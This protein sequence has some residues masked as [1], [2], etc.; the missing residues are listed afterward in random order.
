MRKKLPILLSLV[1]ILAAFCP[2]FTPPAR[3]RAGQNLDA[4]ALEAFFDAY[5]SAEMEKNHVAGA[6]V[7]VVQGEQPLFS[8]GYGYA[9]VAEGLPVDP[10]KTVFILG[11]LSKLFTWTAVMQL[12]ERGQLDLDADVN[13]YLDFHIPDTYPQPI[14]LNHL[15][16]HNAGFEER[17]FGQMAATPGQ[18]TSL[19]D[20]LKSHLPARVRPPGQFSA[21]ENYGAALAGYIVERVSGMDYAEYVEQNILAPL[22]MAHTTARQPIPAALETDMSQGYAFAN[23]AYRPQAGF[24]VAA[25]VAPAAS[26][27]A[28]AGDMA[29]FMLAHLNDGRGL[30]QPAT[31]RWMHTR[32]FAHDP[33][34]NG[35]AHGFWE[36]DMNGQRIIGH[37]GSHFIFS[38]C[39]LLFPEQKLGVFLAVNSQ[40]GMAFV[41]GQNY[42]RFEQAFVDHFFPRELP[43]LS[44]PADFAPRANRFSG[45][46]HLTMGRAQTSPEKLAAL[47]SSVEVLADADGLRVPLL[48]DARFIEIEP[49]VFRQVDD[50]TLL[51]FKADEAGNVTQA[52]LGPNAQSALIKDRWFETPAFNLTLLGGWF[53]LFLS[54]EAAAGMRL[55]LQRRR[56]QPE[57]AT[58][59]ERAARGVAGLAG[60][61]GLLALGGGFASIFNIYGLYTGDLPLWPFVQGLS[62]V[63]AVLAPGMVIFSFL[64]W[65]RGSFG[66]PERLHYTLVTLAAIGL[67]W[68]LWFWN[69]L[70]KGF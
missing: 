4:A 11:S 30:L 67:V 37:A 33:R 34:V 12:A 41:G 9:N 3:A 44:P 52:F 27:R 66:W 49:L 62:I 25:N 15:M 13:T 24:N 26:F 61:C 39:L 69:V 22:G 54:F 23:G 17:K 43:P 6:V 16:A 60:L 64:L 46:Y 29:R 58:S 45:S 31:A 55:F 19:G 51:V 18:M 5:L 32:S 57:T 14:T 35:M 10:E 53:L 48:Q 7:T 20:W 36:M 65:R 59:L 42:L 1:A 56:S 68:F 2:A 38:S 63:V 47:L 70:G 8:K 21:Y 40:G 28:S 50:D